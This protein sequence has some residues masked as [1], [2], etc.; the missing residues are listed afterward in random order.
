MWDA[1]L[2]IFSDMAAYVQRCLA[3]YR[4]VVSH[5]ETT[6]SHYWLTH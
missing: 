4:I 6:L 2:Y 3:V 1:E 5:S